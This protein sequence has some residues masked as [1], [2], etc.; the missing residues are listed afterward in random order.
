MEERK[1]R[2][3]FLIFLPTMIVGSLISSS[4]IENCVLDGSSTIQEA[5]LQCEKKMVV[6]LVLT[7][8][9]VIFSIF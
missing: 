5:S 3:F 6:T 9:Q 4:R 7:N 2:L 8:G 1:L